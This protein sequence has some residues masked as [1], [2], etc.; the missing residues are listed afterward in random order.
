MCVAERE[1]NR[2]T[3]HVSLRW[4]LLTKELFERASE[5]PVAVEELLA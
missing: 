2:F 5:A 1:D 3:W 4:A